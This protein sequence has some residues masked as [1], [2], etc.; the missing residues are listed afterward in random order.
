[1][2]EVYRALVQMNW[3]KLCDRFCACPEA[4]VASFK[5]SRF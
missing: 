3:Q 1:M 5:L 2:S 4:C